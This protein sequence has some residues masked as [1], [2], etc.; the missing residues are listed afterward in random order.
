VSKSAPL[1]SLPSPFT[2]L[3]AAALAF[4]DAS[5][6]DINVAD[7]TFD[8]LVTELANGRSV[9]QVVQELVVEATALVASYNM[10]SRFLVALDVAGKSN[11]LVPW[12]VD[13]EEVRSVYIPLIAIK[14]ANSIHA[15]HTIPI[16]GS[17]VQ[18]IPITLYAVK[19]TIPSL[20]QRPWLIFANSLL[21]NTSLWSSVTPVF[22]SRGYNIILFD[23]RGH[24]KSSI[25]SS[26]CTMPELGRDIAHVLDYFKIQTVNT[27]IGVSQGGASALSFSIQ[28]PG[29]AGKII[30][31]DTQ[32]KA[33]ESNK[34]AWD[35]RIKLAKSSD[36]GMERLAVVTAQRWFPAG[37]VYHPVDPDFNADGNH[38][39]PILKMIA[40][41]PSQGFEHSA[42][43]LQTYDLLA[44]GLL[45]SNTK[46]LLVA[47][48]KD[49]GG[50]ISKALQQL[51]ENWAKEGGNVRFAEVKGAGHLPMV[52]TMK[53]WIQVIGGFL[54]E[55]G[56]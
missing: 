32:A 48:E 9:E 2:S 16:P 13:R 8:A 23:Q 43:A 56:D 45:R 52:G 6:K 27:V 19:L 40:T 31:C 21:T 18:G 17:D 54:Q 50:A 55:G 15:Q 37:S 28:Y 22:I 1:P 47:G 46:T 39:N 10:V 44:D 24:G 4:A 30:A 38:D 51:T 26:E 3:Q 25:P 42:R 34:Q 41:T 29:R 36:D 7:S 12:P 33:P 20:D 5:T 14:Q 49:G 35:D 11:D 53:Q